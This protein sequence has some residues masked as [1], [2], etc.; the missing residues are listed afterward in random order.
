MRTLWKRYVTD[1]R[2]QTD[3][4][5]ASYR[6][7]NTANAVDRRMIIVVLTAMFVLLLIRF[8]GRSHEAKWLVELLDSVGLDGLSRR[9]DYALFESEDQKFNK[10]VFWAAAR[11]I[12]YILIPL[13]V[14]KFVLREP[15]ANFG[16]RVK[17]IGKHWKIYATLFLILAPALIWASYDQGFQNKYPYYKLSA[18]ES[19]WPYFVGWEV[20]YAAQFVA[21]EFF[22]RGFLVHGTKLR[23][24]FGAV[25]V[26]MMPYLMIHF[27]KPLPEAIGSMIAGFVLGT[28]SL[29]SNSVWWGAAIHIAAAVSM[30]L[31][32]LWHRG[33]LT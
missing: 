20:L 25:F 33:F 13:L 19:L 17:G 21:L 27:G 11:V 15:V 32:S 29:K 2:D 9:V 18:G 8:Y 24:G 1:V 31:L 12:G 22:F 30:D 16:V 6:A 26:M 4:A 14:I 7:E 23:F 10:R 5:S 3:A 28:L